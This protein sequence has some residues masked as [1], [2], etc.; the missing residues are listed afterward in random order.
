MSFGPI[1]LVIIRFP[2][3]RFLEEVNPALREVIESRLV[4][5]IDLVF[6]KKDGEGKV[7]A[8]E[9]AEFDPDQFNLPDSIV[10]ET[11]GLLTDDD[12]ARL[13]TLLEPNSSAAIVLFENAWARRLSEA[14]RGAGGEVLVNQRLP[15]A[16]IESLLAENT[17]S[18]TD[19][20]P[21]TSQQ[22]AG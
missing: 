15:R 5:I 14:I 19:D 17:T 6:V 16:V 20:S 21:L 7:A 13:G 22:E 3:N 8:A 2:G 9:V 1:E 11:T 12:I 10:H 4:Q 18:G